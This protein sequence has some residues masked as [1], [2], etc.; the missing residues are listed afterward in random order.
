MQRAVEVS[1]ALS[2]QAD[3][4]ANQVDLVEVELAFADAEIGQRIVEGRTVLWREAERFE[5]LHE[6]RQF[7]VVSHAQHH[8]E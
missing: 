2:P 6:D 4:I 1:S 3:R 8:I 7:V 5:D